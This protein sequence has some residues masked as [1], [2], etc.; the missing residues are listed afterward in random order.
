MLNTPAFA[1]LLTTPSPPTYCTPHYNTLTTQLEPLTTTPHHLPTLPLTLTLTT[2]L[3]YPSPPTY[4]SITTTPSP[5]TYCT[6]HYI[7]T[8]LY[9]P[10]PHHPAVRTPH[11]N[12][13]TPP[14]LPT[15]LSINT[16]PSP[17]TYCTPHY[18]TTSPPS[19]TYPSLQHP[20][21]PPTVPLTTHLLYPSPPTY[22]TPQHPPTSR[23]L[24]HPHHTHLL[25]PS[26]YIYTTPSPPAMDV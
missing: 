1:A 15:Y 9:I 20:H 12:T 24:P 21:H 7:Y 26:L 16:T 11:Y 8:N 19:C 18:T 22:C 23:S 13:L 10:H 3:L 6:P 2:H 25:Y 14:S 5:P 4:L 17:S